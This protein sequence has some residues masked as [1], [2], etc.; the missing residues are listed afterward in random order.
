MDNSGKNIFQSDDI[1]LNPGL[2]VIIGGRSTGKSL[3][4]YFAA[5]TIDGDE[6]VRRFSDVPPIPKYEQ[7]MLEEMEPSDFDFEVY[8][9]D[10]AI[11]KYSQQKEEHRKILYI[12]Q[13]YLSSLSGVS[14][15]KKSALNDFIFDVIMQDEPVKVEYNKKMNQVRLTKEQIDIL[16]SEYFSLKGAVESKKK[17]I[18]ETGDLVAI[19]KYVKAIKVKIEELKKESG[20]TKPQVDELKQLVSRRSVLKKV[21]SDLQQD[22]EN[23]DILLTDIGQHFTEVEK[24]L[25]EKLGYIVDPKIKSLVESKTTWVNKLNPYVTKARAEIIENIE[26][27]KEETQKELNGIEEKLR[28]LVALIKKQQEIQRLMELQKNEEERINTIQSLRDLIKMDSKKLENIGKQCLILYENIIKIYKDLQAILKRAQT[29]LGDVILN[30]KISF[31]EDNFNKHYVE[32]FINR[33]DIKRILGET[34]EQFHYEYDETTHFDKIK[35]I[36]E[37]LMSGSLKPLNFRSAEEATRNLLSDYWSLDFSVTYEGDT[38]ENMSP[39]KMSLTLLKLLILLRN[40]SYPIFIDQPE[41]DLDNRSVY[42]E[43]VKYIENKKIERQIVLV[44]HNPNLVV[45][46]DAELV[47]VANQG[48]S[49]NEIYQFE[50]VSGSLE[51]TVPQDV[52]KK[53]VLFRQGIREHICEILEGGRE[54]FKKREEKYNFAK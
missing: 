32:S 45:G 42:T 20:L 38:L 3:L 39:G 27:K 47:I 37:A 9:K 25:S 52:G 46:A 44:T 8:W 50:Y 4:L 22:G 43:L 48:R 6:V 51:N 12:P 23:V 16:V 18:E 33:H 1:E 2:N 10:G 17:K 11:D 7:E 36:T 49:E 19:L 40:D 34:T 41:A 24:L 26:A 54:A 5:K 14:P 31:K 29:S 53:A 15:E 30:V 35:K 21:A 28:P 13:N